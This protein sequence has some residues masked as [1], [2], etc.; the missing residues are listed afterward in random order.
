[1]G[2]ALRLKGK[3]TILYVSQSLQE[4]ESAHDRILVLENGRIALDGSL[5]R[6][7]GSTFEFHQFQIE[8]NELDDDL[9]EKLSKNTSCKTLQELVIVCIFTVGREMFSLKY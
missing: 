8:F 9:F 6:L 1:M 2:P 4:V 7:L 5:D 3:K